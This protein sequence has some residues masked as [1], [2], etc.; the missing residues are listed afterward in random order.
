MHWQL[1]VEDISI[2]FQEEGPMP[3]V[4][5]VIYWEAVGGVAPKVAKKLRVVAHEWAMSTRRDKPGQR[6][7]CSVLC[8]E[9]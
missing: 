3:Q 2:G 1:W 9:V 5:A 8:E 4:G 7:R 6:L